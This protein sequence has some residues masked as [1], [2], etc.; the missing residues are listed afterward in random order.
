M[1]KIPTVDSWS[2][3]AKDA[4]ALVLLEPSP[5]EID[6]GMRIGRDPRKVTLNEF[7]QTGIAGHPLL[8]VIR[9]KCLDCCGEQVEEVRKCIAFTCPNWPYRMGA[10]PF[11]VVNLT[12]AEIERRRERGRKLAETRRSAAN[13][14]QSTS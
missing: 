14:S 13:E 7:E 9:A 8:E 11:R 4:A 1:L 2:R 10:N 6:R 3:S 12:D 5:F